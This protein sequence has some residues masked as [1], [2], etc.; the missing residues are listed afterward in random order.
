M[1]LFATVGVGT[2][3]FMPDCDKNNTLLYDSS[4]RGQGDPDIRMLSTHTG[5]VISLIAA[6]NLF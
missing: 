6:W 3:K 4:K 2:F 1:E 5:L